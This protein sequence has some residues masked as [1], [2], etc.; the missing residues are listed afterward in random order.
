MNYFIVLGLQV[1]SICMATTTVI[2]AFLER[3]TTR[4]MHYKDRLLIGR[5]LIKLRLGP[6][7][8]NWISSR[9][10][11]SIIVLLII[12]RINRRSSHLLN[13]E[14]GKVGGTNTANQLT[15]QLILMEKTERSS[16]SSHLIPS[17][18][19]SGLQQ[20]IWRIYVGMRKTFPILRMSN[21]LG[22]IFVPV[23][24]LLLKL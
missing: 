8:H 2:P 21:V 17:S 23:L 11:L 12:H 24:L 14:R 15:F 16:S 1:I 7:T 10:I 6:G 4:R 22:Q 3:C 20:W 18:N 13:T 5:N 9:I 19:S